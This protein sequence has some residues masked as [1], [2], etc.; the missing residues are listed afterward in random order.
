M[1]TS[2]SDSRRG[3]PLPGYALLDK[4]EDGMDVGEDAFTNRPAVLG[5]AHDLYD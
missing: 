1:S 3:V 5:S 2:C 4:V